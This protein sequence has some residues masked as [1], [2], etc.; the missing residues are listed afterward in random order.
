MKILFY[1]LAAIAGLFGILALVRMIE[2]A[3]LGGGI[4]LVQIL[5]AVICLFLAVLWIKRARSK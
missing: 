4:N 1:I 5:I 3:A 2:V